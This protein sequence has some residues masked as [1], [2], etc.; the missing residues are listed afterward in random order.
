MSKHRGLVSIGL[1]FSLLSF[2]AAFFGQTEKNPAQKSAAPSAAHNDLIDPVVKRVT[3]ALDLKPDQ[4]SQFRDILQTRLDKLTDLR[5]RLRNQPYSPRFVAD[6]EAE[7]KSVKEQLVPLLTDDQKAKVAAFDLHVLPPPP[8][9][10]LINLPAREDTDSPIQAETSVAL[11]QAKGRVARLTEDQKI[12][13]LLNRATYG[14]RPGDMQAVRNMGIDAYLDQQLHPETIDD[15][16]IESMLDVLPTLHFSVEELYDYYPDPTV[17]EKRVDQ[18]NAPPVYGRP[19]QVTV[20]LTQQKL[21]RAVESKRQL[22]EVMTDFWFNH[23]NVFIEKQPGPFL[24]TSYERDVLRPNALG[25]FRDL[26]L[27]TAKSPAMMFYLDNWLSQAQGASRPHQPSNQSVPAKPKPSASPQPDKNKAGTDS[28]PAVPAA[29]TQAKPQAAKTSPPKPGVNE[30]YARELMELHTLGVDGGYTQKDVQEV[31]RC[32]TG[33][34]LDH[35]YQGNA[36]FVYRPWMH[37]RGA[38]TVLGVKIPAGGGFEDGLKVIDILSHHPS[39][40]HFIS[41]ELCERFVSDDPPDQLVDRVARVFLKSD[42]DISETLRAIFTSPEF[43]SPAAFRS[44]IKSPLELAASAIRA[45]DGETDGGPAIEGWISRAG[46]SLYQYQFPTGYGE[47]SSRW[48]NSGVFLNR[49]NFMVELA[50]NRIKGTRYDPARFPASEAGTHGDAVASEK[51]TAATVD[52]LS[53][54]II[55]TNLSGESRRALTVSM[56]DTGHAALSGAKGAGSDQMQAPR[57][58]ATAGST[59]R[60]GPAPASYDQ[61]A[62]A[63]QTRQIIE[64]LLGTAEFQRR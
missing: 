50:N 52:R 31:A 57:L 33:W 32:F 14:P 28:K 18:K 53:A 63:R 61:S 36:S 49:L 27:A 44:K 21:V 29:Q 60:N 55:H 22:Q 12:L 15:S 4:V 34:T 17:A 6:L 2:P 30:N 38:K 58:V 13:Q 45:L 51:E 1:V 7:N 64:L 39:T 20:E 40:A 54:L 37:D 47:N 19:R 41:K 48:V 56:N 10:I 62:A 11:P 26:L 59:I 24:L 43:N 9:F 46:E 25:K 16:A 42:G 3:E 35:G 23:F 8:G 5:N